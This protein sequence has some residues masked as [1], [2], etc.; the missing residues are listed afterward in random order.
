MA[1]DFSLLPPEEP[2][3]DDPPSR[4]VW[5]IVF[6]VLVLAGVFAVLLLWPKNLPTQTWKFWTCLIL[7]PVGI[8]T[9]VVMRRFGNYEGLKMDIELRNE[10]T[11]GYTE[12]VFEVASRPLALVASAHRSRMNACMRTATDEGSVLHLDVN[13]MTTQKQT[14]ATP[15]DHC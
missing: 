3:P 5:V 14:G 15:Y 2:N 8:P 7:F 4:L 13:P 1:I 10:A 9:L 11:R 12:H 6:F